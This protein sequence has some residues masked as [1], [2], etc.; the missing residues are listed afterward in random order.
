MKEK[1]KLNAFRK[2]NIQEKRLK[3]LL[4]EIKTFVTSSFVKPSPVNR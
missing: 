4:I 1:I 2:K 3:R